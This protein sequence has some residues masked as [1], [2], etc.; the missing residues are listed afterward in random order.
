MHF[1]IVKAV[2]VLKIASYFV[3]ISVRNQEI[4]QIEYDLGNGDNM[5]GAKI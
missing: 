2:C 4:C 1:L 5:L 3:E